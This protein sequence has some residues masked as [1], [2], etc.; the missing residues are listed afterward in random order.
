MFE[1]KEETDEPYSPWL[2]V[3]GLSGAFI[4]MVGLTLAAMAVIGFL[5]FWAGSAIQT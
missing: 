4:A 3:V 5:I 2:R 1:F